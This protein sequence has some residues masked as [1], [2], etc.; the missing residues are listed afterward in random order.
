[1]IVFLILTGLFFLTIS[2]LYKY[3]SGCVDKNSSELIDVEIKEGTS[4][5]N[6][7]TILKEKGLIKSEVFFKVYLKFMNVKGL[8]AGYYQLSKNMD[9]DAIIK[10]LQEVSTYNPNEI[11]ITFQDGIN[12]RKIAT[13]IEKNTNNTYD[14]VMKTQS[15]QEFLK[16]LIDKYWFITDDILDSKIYYP[17]EGYLYPNTYNFKNKDVTPKEIF[18]RLLDEMDKQL[19][20]IKGDMEKNKYS[21]HELLTLASVAHLEV[22]SKTDRPKVVS[23][24]INRLNKKMSWGSDITTRYSVKLD[25]T[26]AL[27]KAEY[28]T[29]NDYNT[30]GTHLAGKMPAGPICAMTIDTIKAAVYPESTEYLFFISRIKTGE[31]FFYK[32]ESDFN[33]KKAELSNENNGY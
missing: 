3:Y 27:T 20:E 17:L 13:I 1:M 5:I 23:V 19:E 29:I 28:N 32:N 8:N 22:R 30:R 4:G 15:D 21:V 10:A 7:G 11:S 12:M 33:R 2:C 9:V 18:I 14:D 31:T 25:D 6:I 26:R 16:E 24:F